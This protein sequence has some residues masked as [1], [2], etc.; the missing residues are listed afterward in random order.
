MMCSN[1]CSVCGGCPKLVSDTTTRAHNSLRS[2]RTAH[3]QGMSLNGGIITDILQR[4]LRLME[5]AK[6]IIRESLP[7]K[8][9]EA[10]VV[11]LYLTA[12][13]TSMQR[14]AIS[15]KS[16]VGK[17]Y[18]RQEYHTHASHIAKQCVYIDT[19]DQLLLPEL[20]HLCTKHC[21]YKCLTKIHV[22]LTELTKTPCTVFSCPTKGS[23]VPYLT[24]PGALCNSW[25]FSYSRSLH[26][27][28]RFT[29]P[30]THSHHFLSLSPTDT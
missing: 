30:L 21:I 16:S 7:I 15:F 27:A 5:T 11:A 23:G 1:N 14:F 19:M 18:Y 3:C 24:E 2:E 26:C 29:H 22:Y 13:L 8:C 28:F 20:G 12:P 9:L 10:V 17:S 25:N 6:E 4:L